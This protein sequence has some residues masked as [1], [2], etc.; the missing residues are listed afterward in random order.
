MPNVAH[1]LTV[2]L[3]DPSLDIPLCPVG[4]WRG[5]LVKIG[6]RDQDADGEPLTDKNGDEYM[7]V[8]LICRPEAPTEDVDKREA[9]A[10]I[11]AGGPAETV[12]SHS[13]FVRGK[14]SMS[15]VSKLLIALGVPTAGRSMK[16]I[17]D[18]Y[19]GGVPCH[20]EVEHREGNDGETR[21]DI[22][23]IYPAD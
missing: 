6:Y 10:W 20:F 17:A 22:A 5:E 21:E 3:D 7:M 2:P 16:D 11:E 13:M 9:K 8:R 15:R 19:K 12:L 14:R 23:D 1:L 18:T 4:T